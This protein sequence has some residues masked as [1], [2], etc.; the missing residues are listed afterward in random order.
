MEV[1]L[2]AAAVIPARALAP[3]PVVRVPALAAVDNSEA[4]DDFT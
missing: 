4:Q 2:V 3:V 1:V